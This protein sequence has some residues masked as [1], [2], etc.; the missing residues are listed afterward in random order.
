MHAQAAG[1]DVSAVALLDAAPQNFRNPRGPEYDPN[2]SGLAG[3]SAFAPFLETIQLTRANIASTERDAS[4][5][6]IAAAAQCRPPASPST[7]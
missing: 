6:V 2:L 4:Q 7:P 5:L 3:Q 1:S